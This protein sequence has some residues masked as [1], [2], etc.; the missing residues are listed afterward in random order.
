MSETARG[1]QKFTIKE[2]DQGVLLDVTGVNG[3]GSIFCAAFSTM[4]E[5]C[6]FI[7]ERHEGSGAKP[8]PMPEPMPNTWPDGLADDLRYGAPIPKSMLEAARTPEPGELAVDEPEPETF[9][10]PEPAPKQDINKPSPTAGLTG[11]QEAVLDVLSLACV[12]T[13]KETVMMDWT[14]LAEKAGVKA[15]SIRY[16][17]SELV[18]K[19]YILQKGEPGFP[20][21]F[22]VPGALDGVDDEGDA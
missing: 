2:L 21:V 17:V 8:E 4:N 10:D 5:A 3:C 1:L 18:R 12:R 14:K 15:G 6:R 11:N 16:L 9:A 22:T 7:L 13:G 19:E 20:P